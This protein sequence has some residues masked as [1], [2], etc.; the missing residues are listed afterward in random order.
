MITK[1]FDFNLK[2]FD[3]RTFLEINFDAVILAIVPI[4]SFQKVIFLAF[5]AKVSNVQIGTN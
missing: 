5:D 3:L 4:M 2:G 1:K